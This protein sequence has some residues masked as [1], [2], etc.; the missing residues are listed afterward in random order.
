MF[1][2]RKCGMPSPWALY[3][4]AVRKERCWNIHSVWS[5]EMCAIDNIQDLV[6][7]LVEELFWF[8]MLRYTNSM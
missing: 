6:P 3:A 8:S 7:C 4:R 1:D 5:G 2:R